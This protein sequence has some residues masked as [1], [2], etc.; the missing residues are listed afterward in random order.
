LDPDE[1]VSGKRCSAVFLKD[2][3]GRGGN[4][5]MPERN[6]ELNPFLKKRLG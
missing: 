2:L 6:P 4:E 5:Y 1:S 3:V